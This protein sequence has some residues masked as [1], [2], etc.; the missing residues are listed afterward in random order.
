MA[1][2]LQLLK[3]SEVAKLLNVDRTAIWRWYTTGD[4]PKPIKVGATTRFRRTDIEAWLASRPNPQ[5][6]GQPAT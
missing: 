1:A 4:F 5:H 6:N 2:D 3:M